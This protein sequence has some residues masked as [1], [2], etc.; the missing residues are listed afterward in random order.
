[1]RRHL[2]GRR[3]QQ[4]RS[5]RIGRCGAVPRQAGGPQP[6]HARRDQ[7][8][9]RRQR[10]RLLQG[11]QR[12]RPPPTMQSRRRKLVKDLKQ[13]GELRG[14]TTAGALTD[15][16]YDEL[17]DLPTVPL[18]LGRIRRLLKESRQLGLLSISVL[19]NDRGEQTL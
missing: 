6:R 19:Q 18:L 16:L 11:E 1:R 5:H 3:S 13:K 2:P 8:F 15:L 17:T 12:L 9:L 4:H 10:G 7:V 14:A